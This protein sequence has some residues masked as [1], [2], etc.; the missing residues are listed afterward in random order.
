MDCPPT[1]GDSPFLF[2]P[3]FHGLPINGKSIVSKNLEMKIRAFLATKG[4]TFR[5]LKP[6]NDLLGRTGQ[7]IYQRLT[8]R[9]R[10]PEFFRPVPPTACHTHLLS[11]L[12]PSA[13]FM[14]R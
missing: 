10:D 7:P 13:S 3:G 6:E 9:L 14:L 5:I 2:L 12:I 11:H 8:H 1:A 4:L